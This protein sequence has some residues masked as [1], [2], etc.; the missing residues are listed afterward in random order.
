MTK[1]YGW[2]DRDG[3]LW[4]SKKGEVIVSSKFNVNGERYRIVVNDEVKMKEQL[5][6]KVGNDDWNEAAEQA[7]RFAEGY[8]TA[9]NNYPDN[10]IPS[11]DIETIEETP[12]NWTRVSPDYTSS[13]VAFFVGGFKSAD[14]KE[15]LIWHGVE[16]EG[17]VSFEGVD[18]NEMP[19]GSKYMVVK[20]EGDE[21][22]RVGF[23]RTEED[24]F[25]LA[26][27]ETWEI[28][29]SEEKTAMDLNKERGR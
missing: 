23:T 16:H 12:R 17:T 15:I 28:Q 7:I 8:I 13:T 2:T 19:D 29:S 1:G 14:G 26:K 10:L 27:Q 9:M 21:Y 24:A 6:L 22:D 4:K 3:M 25:N 20:K 18:D 11:E 5:V